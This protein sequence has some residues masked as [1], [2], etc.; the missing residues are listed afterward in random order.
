LT[1]RPSELDDAAA[2]ERS[3]RADSLPQPPSVNA[4]PSARRAAA[5][6]ALAEAEAD[7]KANEPYLPEEVKVQLERNLKTLDIETA[8]REHVLSR[9]A[10]CLAAAVA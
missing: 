8:D 2:L 6:G 10:A 9:G 1:E 3:Q 5:E 7:Y 4:E